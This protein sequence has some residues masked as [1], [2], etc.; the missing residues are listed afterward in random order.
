MGQQ[1]FIK[2][3]SIF[4]G[5]FIALG[6]ILAV[7]WWVQKSI[8]EQVGIS[9]PKY[10][11]LK[12]EVAQ[13][14][15]QGQV[16]KQPEPVKQDQALIAGANE[17]NPGI[18]RPVVVAVKNESGNSAVENV[19][20]TNTDLGASGSDLS[21]AGSAGEGSGAQGAGGGSSFSFQDFN[22]SGLRNGTGASQGDNGGASSG[23]GGG[24]G[25]GAE[26]NSD[27]TEGSDSQSDSGS[28]GGSSGQPNIKYSTVE[29]ILTQ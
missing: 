14:K 27:S 29:E 1:G 9:A 5:I 17:P 25:L 18:V 10:E 4:W 6:A 16:K 13:P 22:S 21:G 8:D 19:D 24:G 2:M 12:I 11:P 3:G 26:S 20:G 23:G 7:A 15:E 28:S